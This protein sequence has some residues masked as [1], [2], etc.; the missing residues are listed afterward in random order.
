MTASP[1]DEEPELIDVRRAAA[2]VGRH[3]ETIRRW[4]W[5]GRLPAAR[6]GRRLLVAASEVRRLGRSVGPLGSLAEW[7]DLRRSSERLLAASGSGRGAADIVIED[8]RRRGSEA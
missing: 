1:A 3:P 6:S 7:L 4:V 5:S 8:R 2:L